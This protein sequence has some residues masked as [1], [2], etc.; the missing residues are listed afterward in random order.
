MDN[1]NT[2]KRGLA[3]CPFTEYD[4]VWVKRAADVGGPGLRPG[5]RPGPAKLVSREGEHSFTCCFLDCP[6]TRVHVSGLNF[7]AVY[8]SLL[9]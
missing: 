6:N 5:P 4:R 8:M 1:W 9:S 3:I 2:K 7:D